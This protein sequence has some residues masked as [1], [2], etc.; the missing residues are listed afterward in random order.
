MSTAV[1]VPLTPNPVSV[2]T[3]VM[4]GCAAVVTVPAVVAVVALETVPDTFDP[5]TELATAAKP[6]SPDTFAPA[7]AF[8]VAAKLTSPETLAPATAFAVAAL[9]T[10]P[11]TLAPVIAV[12]AEPLPLTDVK[13]P[14]VAL[15][16]PAEAL[17][18][19]VNE[20]RV[21]TLVIFG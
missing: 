16:L 6:T 12:S 1:R 17:P 3:E 5:A 14:A 2:P 7:T 13:S 15:M 9:D 20:E 21:P 4:F 8:A 19:T 10:S 11:V 18:D